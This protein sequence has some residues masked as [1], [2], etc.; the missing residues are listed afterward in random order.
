MTVLVIWLH[1][2]PNIFW[3]DCI[4]SSGVNFFSRTLLR[5]LNEISGFVL[6]DK[7]CSFFSSGIFVGFV[8][9][10]NPVKN[11]VFSCGFVVALNPV[12]N[13]VF[14]CGFVVTFNPVV[15]LV[16]SVGW[17]MGRFLLLENKG[18]SSEEKFSFEAEFRLEVNKLVSLPGWLL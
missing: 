16:V 15:K 6:K 4:V 7:L 10:F 14:S 5:L 11:K 1:G 2:N 8:V 3:I 18:L 17:F 12:E 13:I 9:T